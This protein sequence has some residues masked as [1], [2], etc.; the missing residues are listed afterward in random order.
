MAPG[1]SAAEA[2]IRYLDAG[3]PGDKLT[4]SSDGGGCLPDFDANGE[5]I[6]MDV[7]RCHTLLDTLRKLQSDNVELA[8]AL[9]FFTRN[10]ARLF[11][12]GGKGQVAVGMDAD[13][14]ITDAA[15]QLRDVMARGRWHI[16]DGDAVRRGQF[17]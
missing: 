1:Y 8:T 11:R 9:P 5:L 17:E 13:L 4:V 6:H 14:L 7:G 15:L 12:F 16:R 10:V 2:I 3:L